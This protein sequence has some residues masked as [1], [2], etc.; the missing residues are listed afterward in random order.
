[1]CKNNLKAKKTSPKQREARGQ[2]N[3]KKFQGGV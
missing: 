1:M 2:S 3:F